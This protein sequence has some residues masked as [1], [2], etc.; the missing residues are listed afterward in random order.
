MVKKVVESFS[1][2]S[3]LLNTVM[4][5]RPST[6]VSTIGTAGM[7][8]FQSSGLVPLHNTTYSMPPMS[9]HSKASQPSLSGV[10]ASSAVSS[11]GRFSE[12]PTSRFVRPT[13]SS[14][15]SSSGSPA[16]AKLLQTANPRSSDRNIGRGNDRIQPGEDRLEGS[17]DSARDFRFNS[18]RRSAMHDNPFVAKQ[19]ALGVDYPNADIHS[20]VDTG[21]NPPAGWL[22]QAQTRTFRPVANTQALTSV[23]RKASP[24]PHKPAARVADYM[25][26]ASEHV[27]RADERIVGADDQAKGS[28]S[29]M[30]DG[31]CVTSIKRDSDADPVKTE[32]DTKEWQTEKMGKDEEEEEGSEEWVTMVWM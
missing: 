32:C 13:E 11:Q 16:L 21:A 28:R 10:A 27:L 17:Q 5:Q 14:G 20:A 3:Q 6:T 18:S 31:R 22:S 23:D 24:G 9:S 26:Q 8:I 2:L 15:L 12:I 30:S 25:L 4:S 7:P 29:D 19:P 1:R